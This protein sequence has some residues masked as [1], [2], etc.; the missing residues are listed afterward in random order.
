MSKFEGVQLIPN[1]PNDEN[2][3][4]AEANKVKFSDAEVADMKSKGMSD[5]DISEKLAR[6]NEGARNFKIISRE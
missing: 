2:R 6:A 3:V 1:E 5:Q 4:V